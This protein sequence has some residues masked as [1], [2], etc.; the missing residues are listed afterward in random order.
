MLLMLCVFEFS[1]VVI[2]AF[3]LPPPP[4]ANRQ[5]PVK[6]VIAVVP[7]SSMN[8]NGKRAFNLTALQE[9]IQESTTHSEIMVHVK[10]K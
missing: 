3:K 6:C 8:F 10:L 9:N 1:L 2:F 4:V 7:M 5:L